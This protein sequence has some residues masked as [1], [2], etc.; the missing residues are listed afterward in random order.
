[1]G[2]TEKTDPG[3]L[4]MASA[5]DH[6]CASTFTASFAPPL[7]MAIGVR[8]RHGRQFFAARDTPDPSRIWRTVPQVVESLAGP[9]THRR[10]RSN[11][12]FHQSTSIQ[13]VLEW[14]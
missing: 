2:P 1:M 11:S 8:I 9:Q 3:S 5:W 13:S 10:L 7:S 12:E 14:P 6:S 4:D